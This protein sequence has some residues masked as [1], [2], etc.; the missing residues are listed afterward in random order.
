MAPHDLRSRHKVR[1]VS[2]HTAGWPTH[3][4]RATARRKDRRN[5]ASRRRRGLPAPIRATQ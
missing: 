1:V 3:K 2:A 5:Q 4:A